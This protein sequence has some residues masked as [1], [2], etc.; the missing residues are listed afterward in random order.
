[1]P[2]PHGEPIYRRFDEDGFEIVPMGIAAQVKAAQQDGYMPGLYDAILDSGCAGMGLLNPDL[3]AIL[4]TASGPKLSITG[5]ISGQDLKVTSYAEIPHFGL[6]PSHRS[7]PIS[8]ILGF[9]YLSDKFWISYQHQYHRFVILVDRD[10]FIVFCR[11]ANLYVGDLR[12]RY[13]A[14]QVEVEVTDS[15]VPTPL[16]ILQTVF[17]EYLENVALSGA[18]DQSSPI[19]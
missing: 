6:I 15:G 8:C 1:M 12:N 3:C 19:T 7:C 10:A 2:V 18:A 11:T 13:T 4:A 16:Q 5:V 9:A 14:A 17:L